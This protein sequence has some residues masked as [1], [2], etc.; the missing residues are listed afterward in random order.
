[1]NILQRWVHINIF[2]LQFKE[3][4][5]FTSYFNELRVNFYYILKT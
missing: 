1:M 4:D 3:S 5:N 2:T